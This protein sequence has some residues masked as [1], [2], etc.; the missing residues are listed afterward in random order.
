MNTAMMVIFENRNVLNVLPKI[1]PLLF[2]IRYAEW[3][4]EVSEYLEVKTHFSL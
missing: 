3:N 4:R 2:P 1:S